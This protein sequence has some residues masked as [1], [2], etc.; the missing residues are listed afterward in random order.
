[1]GEEKEESGGAAAAAG[2]DLTLRGR[3]VF[4]S[5]FS[6]EREAQPQA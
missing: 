3:G 5:R 4:D 2:G 6:T 1:M